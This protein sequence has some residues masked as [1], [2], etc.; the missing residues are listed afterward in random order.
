[1]N[2]K[3]AAEGDKATAIVNAEK[4]AQETLI[5]AD[6]QAQANKKLEQSLT[7]GIVQYE[8]IKKWN[9]AQSIVNGGSNSMIQL[10]PAM[11]ENKE[12]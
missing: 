4:I 1:L 9:G 10:P 12:K 11:F 3:L 6:A 8:W 2:D 5:K 7:P